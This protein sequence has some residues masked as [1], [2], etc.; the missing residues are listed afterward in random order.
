[1]LFENTALRVTSAPAPAPPGP[2]IVEARAPLGVVAEPD[3]E[4]GGEVSEAV[5]RAA[6]DTL[7][8]YGGCRVV[9][10]LTPGAPPRWQVVPQKR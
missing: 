5:R 6:S 9:A 1:V 4:C 7:A 3:A 8:Q 10:D 2:L